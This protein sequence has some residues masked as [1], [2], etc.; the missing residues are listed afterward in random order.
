MPTADSS[1][2]PIHPS[3]MLASYHTNKYSNLDQSSILNGNPY[4]T[5]GSSGALRFNNKRR[6]NVV[7]NAAPSLLS[8]DSTGKEPSIAP[9]STGFK[10]GPGLKSW[11]ILLVFFLLRIAMNWQRRSFSYIFG[12]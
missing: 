2:G 6:T 9:T 11:L 7:M 3:E 5:T 4:I 1:V 8:S 10:A 12:F